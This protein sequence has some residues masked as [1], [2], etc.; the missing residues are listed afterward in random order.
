MAVYVDVDD[1]LVRSFGSK[2]IPMT[3]MVAFVRSL[4]QQ[5]A[6]LY[7]WSSGGAEYARRSA[8][9]LGLGDC[10]IAY[11]PKP[12]VLIDD[13]AVDKWKMRQ[14]HPNECRG[15]DASALVAGL[16]WQSRIPAPDATRFTL[17]EED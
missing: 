10:F 14:L 17:S 15:L 9:E 12:H 3:E 8:E 1:T 4:K 6:T 5:G 7:C 13:V 2:R 16:D 11:L